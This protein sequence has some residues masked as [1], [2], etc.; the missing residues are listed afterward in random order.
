MATDN[1]FLSMRL[2]KH[3]GCPLQAVQEHMDR[4]WL[5]EKRVRLFLSWY[6]E[7]KKNSVSQILRKGRSWKKGFALAI[8]KG[9][10]NWRPKSHVHIATRIIVIIATKLLPFKIMSSI[11]DFMLLIHFLHELTLLSFHPKREMSST[12]AGKAPSAQQC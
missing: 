2:K 1:L 10:M 11:D 6:Q 4:K 5:E 9:N 8:R 7:G 12:D 3:K